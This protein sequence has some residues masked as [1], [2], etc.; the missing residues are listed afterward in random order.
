V[1]YS[2]GEHKVFELPRDVRYRE[3]F[4]VGIN[5]RFRNH[6]CVLI[7]VFKFNFF[8]MK[9]SHYARNGKDSSF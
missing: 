7:A 6:G 4:H 8:G 5:A 1:L 2:G 9:C 3:K